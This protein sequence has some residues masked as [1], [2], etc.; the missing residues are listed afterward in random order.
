MKTILITTAFLVTY[1]GNAQNTLTHMKA[2]I[3]QTIA[4]LFVAVDQSDWHSVKTI[5]ADT[6]YLDYSSMNNQPGVNV[7]S[8]D[9]T[10]QWG[11]VLPG[12]DFTHHQIGNVIIEVKGKAAHAFC[13]GTATHYL[14]HDKGNLWTVVGSYDFDLKKIDD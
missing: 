11:A 7:S 12:F 13:Y 3:S 14:N 1:V 8:E 5:F 4:Q 2:D 10:K 6:I 9:I